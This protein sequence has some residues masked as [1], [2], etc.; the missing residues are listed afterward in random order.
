MNRP[1]ESAHTGRVIA[2]QDFLRTNMEMGEQSRACS[3]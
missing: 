1:L 3:G 2:V